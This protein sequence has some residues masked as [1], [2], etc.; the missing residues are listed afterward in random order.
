VHLL[1]GNGQRELFPG[2]EKDK[3]AAIHAQEAR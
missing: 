2:W 1:E 3:L